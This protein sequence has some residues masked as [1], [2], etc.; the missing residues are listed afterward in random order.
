MSCTAYPDG[1][2]ERVTLQCTCQHLHEHWHVCLQESTQ[3]NNF[4]QAARR[5]PFRKHA[6]GKGQANGSSAQE[7]QDVKPG[8]QQTV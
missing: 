3:G 6:N 5:M 7:L 8:A 2:Q 1:Q 4:W